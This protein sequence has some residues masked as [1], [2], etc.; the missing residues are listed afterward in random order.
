MDSIKIKQIYEALRKSWSIETSSKWTSEN[1]A[2]GQ[3]GVTA[4][5]M[6]GRDKKDEDRRSV[7]FLQYGR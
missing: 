1:P 5:I 2:K 4:L 7:A 6:R 3:C